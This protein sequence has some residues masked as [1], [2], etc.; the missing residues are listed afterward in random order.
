MWG[1]LR[2]PVQVRRYRSAVT[3][4][5]ASLNGFSRTVAERRGEEVTCMGRI[6]C[7]LGDRSVF[8]TEGLRAILRQS[9]VATIIGTTQEPEDVPG[10]VRGCARRRAGELE[11]P[12]ARWPSPGH[13]DVPVLIRTWSRREDDL[14]EPSGPGHGF[15]HKRWSRRAPVRHRGGGRWADRPS[16]PVG[17]APRQPP[18]GHRPPGTDSRIRSRSPAGTGIVQLNRRRA[19]QQGAGRRPR[20]RPPDGQNHAGRDG[21]ATGQLPGPG[22]W[23]SNGATSPRNRRDGVAELIR[24][25]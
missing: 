24:A 14:L 23:A 13:P 7:V 11:P 18:R 9:P 21:Q 3:G 20:H 10:L 22:A 1:C 16:R 17:A 12:P 19:L 4:A 25:F 6:R 5:A 15:L 8:F 2:Y